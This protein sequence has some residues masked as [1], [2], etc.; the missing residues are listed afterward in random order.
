MARQNY[1]KY[2]IEQYAARHPEFTLIESKVTDSELDALEERL[3]VKLPVEL[4]DYFQSYVMTESEIVGHIDGD[5]PEIY[6]EETG[7]WRDVEDDDEFASI[8]FTLVQTPLGD[9]LSDFEGENLI[10]GDDD[11][12]YYIKGGFVYVSSWNEQDALLLDLKSGKILHLM[13]G[14]YPRM[15]DKNLDDKERRN[16]ILE[17]AWVMFNSFNELLDCVFVGTVYEEPDIQLEE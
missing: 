8:T 2:A 3:G 16:L 13:E 6:D 5:F 15:F 11:D 17:E 14:I 10:D 9:E 1:A 7:E 12:N 4:R